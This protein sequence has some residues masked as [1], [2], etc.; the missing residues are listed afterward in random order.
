MGNP[1]LGDVARNNDRAG[2]I[3]KFY[4]SSAWIEGKAEDQLTHLL[5]YP[6]VKRVAAFPDL[7][8]GKYGPVGCAV[9]SKNIHP[10]LIGNDIGCG[11]SLFALDKG[12][13]KLKVDKAAKRLQSLEGSSP[14]HAREYLEGHGLS[15]AL[16]PSSMGT[17]GGGNHF[18]EL[19]ELNE[20]LDEG[21]CVQYDLQKGDR[22]L[23]VHSG[24]RTLGEA[25]FSTVSNVVMEGLDPKSEETTAYM[26]R[27]DEA[28]HWASLNRRLIASRAAQVLGT[29]WRLLT[30]SPH[31][32]IEHHN[33]G[34]LHRKG[35]AKANIPLVPLAGSRDALSYLLKPTGAA[36]RSLASLSHG[37]G[38]KHDR[39]SMHGRFS[40]K[41]AARSQMLRTSFGGRVVCADKNLLLEEA[42][43]AYKAIDQVR[44]D[45]ENFGLGVAIASFK[46]LVTF[47]KGKSS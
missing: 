4:S 10:H 17:I 14:V 47:K 28:V 24:S 33:E 37:A 2:I 31:N 3:Q 15:G 6:A 42:P 18:C 5:N 35:A 9:L 11:M 43:K 13:K 32:L 34:F 23:L 20:V 44:A 45:I 27:H 21:I 40:N 30:D 46:P 26:I 36:E 12:S 22:F 25:V 1:H 29:D 8:P 39:R 7:H 38:R 41:K 16:F 19:Q